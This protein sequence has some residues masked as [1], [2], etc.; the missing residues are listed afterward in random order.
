MLIYLIYIGLAVTPFLFFKGMDSRQPKEFFALLVAATI[1]VF[2]LKN[3]AHNQSTKWFCAFLFWCLFVSFFAPKWLGLNLYEGGN[4]DGIWNYKPIIYMGIFFALTI[5]ISSSNSLLCNFDNISVVVYY[6][7]II[8]AGYVIAQW[9]GIDPFMK[10]SLVHSNS[11][12]PSYKL[13]GT[14][15]HPTI[16]SV[17]IAM[18]IPFGIYLKRWYGVI[19]MIIA[20]LLTKSM[21]AY[22]AL[23][24]GL[25]FYSTNKN[26][27]LMLS[28][29]IVLF[30]IG[31]WLSISGIVT[32]SGRYDIWLTAFKDMLSNQ[33]TFITGFGIGSWQY[34]YPMMHNTKDN[35]LTAHNEYFELFWGTG[36]LSII[37]LFNSVKYLF[38]GIIESGSKEVKVLGASILILLVDAVGNFTFHLGVFCL[39]F[40]IMVGLVFNIVKQ[41]KE[42]CI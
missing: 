7:G 36:I 9:L 40:C 10:D 6:C 33:K 17:F 8:M 15:G 29:F 35:W 20:V 1:S 2:Y 42:Q 24:C 38:I 5:A 3:I 23:A 21:M 39:Y 30:L 22:L 28:V 16:V 26:I 18:T 31:L 13:T 25:I 19:G 27:L 11:A 4:V 32:L 37:F 14:M 12:T 41:E 34:I